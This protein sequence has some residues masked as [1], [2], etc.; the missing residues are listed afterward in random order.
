MASLATLAIFINAL[1]LQHGP[2]PAPIFA[3]RPL[4]MSHPPQAAPPQQETAPQPAPT[5]QAAP[6]Q[7]PAQPMTRAQIVTE[8]QRELARRGFYD[9]AV[10]GVWGA[11][12]DTATRDVLAAGGLKLNP[13][14]GD[15]LLRALATSTVVAHPQAQPHNDPIAALLAP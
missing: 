7:P 15:A 14:A 1:F 6:A 11:K 12:T 8:I 5:V 13:D 9:G 2:H 4:A 10:D 3:T